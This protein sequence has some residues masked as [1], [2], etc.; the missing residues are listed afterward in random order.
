MMK[1]LLK[2]TLLS[3][4]VLFCWHATSRSEEKQV[5]TGPQPAFYSW[6][7]TPPMGW[8]SYDAP[9]HQRYRGRDPGQ[10]PIHEGASPSAWMALYRERCALV[11]CGL[12]LRRQRL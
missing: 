3:C 2:V 1:N 4:S 10:C 5:G 8:N 9:R 6:A 11:R 7:A 12:F